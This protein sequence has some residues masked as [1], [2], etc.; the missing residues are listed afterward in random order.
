[1]QFKGSRWWCWETS[2]DRRCGA[3]SK[4]VYDSLSLKQL[5]AMRQHITSHL[6]RVWVNW[7]VGPFDCWF[8]CARPPWCIFRELSLRDGTCLFI[9]VVVMSSLTGFP[10]VHIL[11]YISLF[12]CFS[13]KFCLRVLKH[14]LSV[15]EILVFIITMKFPISNVRT[16]FC[17]VYLFSVV[18]CSFKDLPWS[19]T[20]L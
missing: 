20:C 17:Y 10:L 6:D 3:H 19:C 8:S 13:C 16:L 12:F 15:R 7:A 18:Y 9:K 5:A 14:H 4:L 11:L 1:M 2:S